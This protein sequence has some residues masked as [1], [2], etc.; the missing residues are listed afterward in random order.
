MVQSS[1]LVPELSEKN[2]SAG[3]FMGYFFALLHYWQGALPEYHSF[4]Y[5][6]VIFVP[7]DGFLCVYF[8]GFWF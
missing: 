8:D 3:I 6:S 2:S 5:K 7:A 1:P 4:T